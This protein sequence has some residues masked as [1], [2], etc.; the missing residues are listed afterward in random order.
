[1]LALVPFGLP[2]TIIHAFQDPISMALAHA[3]AQSTPSQAAAFSRIPAC[4]VPI[5]AS[6]FHQFNHEGARAQNQCAT[7][8]SMRFW[9]PCE[10][11]CRVYGEI[12]L[13]GL[14]P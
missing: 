9:E 12:G 10:Q 4:W 6:A 14:I 7:K 3:V 2:F 13:N 1:M 8:A 11:S 5:K